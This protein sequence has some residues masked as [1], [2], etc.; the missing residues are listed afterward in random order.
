MGAVKSLFQLIGRLIGFIDRSIAIVGIGGGVALAFYNVAA[1]Y[2]FGSSLTWAGELTVYLFLWSAFFGAA[3]CFKRDAHISVTVVLEKMPPGISKILMLF[4]H[5]VTLVFLAAVSWY[6]YEYL[7]LVIELDERSIDLDIPMWVPY[8]AIPLSFASAAWRVAEK[9]VEILRTP[10]DEVVCMGEAEMIL[11]EM[12]E[13]GVG[14]SAKE[15]KCLKGEA[16]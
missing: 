8:L 10:A 3:Y 15:K 1:R 5:S 13:A 12:E 4:S 11:A 6:G 16:P 2:L 9:I 7:E 14:D